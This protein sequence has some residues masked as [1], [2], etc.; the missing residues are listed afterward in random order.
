MLHTI[1]SPNNEQIK[2]L[3]KLLRQKKER[4]Q[5]QLMVLE[6][7]HLIQSYLEQNNIPQSVFIAENK[8]QHPEIKNLLLQ[9]S[10]SSIHIV[11]EKAF[12]RLSQYSSVTDIIAIAHK[13]EAPALPF[14]QSCVV[15]ESIQDSGNVGTI[16]RSAAAAG[17]NHVLLTSGCADAFS[18]KVL[19]A[20]MGAHFLLQI[21][22]HTDLSSFLKN[23][24]GTSIATALDKQS[25]SLY[26]TNLTGQIALIVG[27]EGAGVSPVVQQTVDQCIYIPML[28]QTESLNVAMATTICLFERVRQLQR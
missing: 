9:L 17:I 15:M 8:Q 16:L 3:I 19:R 24:T 14:N 25:H 1:D 4:D 28:G 22:E 2:L 27:N 13:P 7:V 11:S 20:A 26:Q 5:H 6:G 21:N 12:T 23:Y 18:P 10:H